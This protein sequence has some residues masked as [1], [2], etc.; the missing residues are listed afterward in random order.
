MARLLFF[1]TLSQS[2]MLILT[3]LIMMEEAPCIGMLAAKLAF[4]KLLLS[5]WFLAS[6]Y[7]FNCLALHA[8]LETG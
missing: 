8:Y 2:G 1:V 5:N 3:C 6:F 7:F 4:V